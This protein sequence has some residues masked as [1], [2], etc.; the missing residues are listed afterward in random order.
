MNWKK[1]FKAGLIAAAGGAVGAVAQSAQSGPKS[2]EELQAAAIAGALATLAAH[3]TQSPIKPKAPP[4][5]Q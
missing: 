5:E 2:S 1:I 3:L 4:T